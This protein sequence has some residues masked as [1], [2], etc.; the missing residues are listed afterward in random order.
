MGDENRLQ[1]MVGDIASSLHGS[2]SLHVVGLNMEE[3]RES[4]FDEAVG[5]AWKLLGTLDAFVNC[6]AYEG[7]PIKFIFWGWLGILFIILDATHFPNHETLN[8]AFN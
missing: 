4:V 6:Y 7:K 8:S 5:L 1:K 2:C 3:D